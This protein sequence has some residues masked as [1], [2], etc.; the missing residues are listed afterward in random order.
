MGACA[1][2]CGG[3]RGRV[4]CGSRWRAAYLVTAVAMRRKASSFGSARAASNA[5][6]VR[7]TCS[8]VEA[9]RQGK[10]DSQSSRHY[11]GGRSETT[12]KIAQFENDAAC[13]GDGRI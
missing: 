6:A 13:T 2:A 5:F 8:G 12:R 10:H 3:V 4:L 1:R 7:N 9:W 11:N